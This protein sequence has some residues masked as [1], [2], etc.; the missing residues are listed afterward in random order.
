MKK[1]FLL[2]SRGLV[3]NI[4]C[5]VLWNLRTQ[6]RTI[7]ISGTC[8][9][10]PQKSELEVKKRSYYII[11][12]AHACFVKVSELFENALKSKKIF[13]GWWLIYGGLHDL[14]LHQTGIHMS[15][16]GT[17]SAC[18][19]RLKKNEWISFQLWHSWCTQY[20][21]SK[22]HRQQNSMH[23]IIMGV[24]AWSFILI[25]LNHIQT[26]GIW[27]Y[28]AQLGITLLL[29]IID[30]RIKDTINGITFFPLHYK[31]LYQI[32]DWYAFYWSIYDS[33]QVTSCQ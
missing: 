6:D 16:Q 25:S 26:G 17:L 29:S 11:H 13:F 33:G 10:N 23:K 15:E 31:Q 4:L 14:R 3:G 1:E 12:N 8:P 2:G 18:W 7:D 19:C 30:A 5:H 22:D 28:E 27:M 24:H 32:S 9:Q 20:W 21:V